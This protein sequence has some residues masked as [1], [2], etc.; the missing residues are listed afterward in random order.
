M[1]GRLFDLPVTMVSE[2]IFNS[3][4][5]TADDALVVVD[6]GLPSVASQMLEALSRSEGAGPADISTVVCTHGHS[7]HVGGVSTLLSGCDAAV[8]LPAR[9]ESYLAGELPRA[10]PVIESSVRFMPVY[11]EQPFSLR[12]LREFL[13]Q[14]RSIGWGAGNQMT[15]DFD[16]AGFLS[17]GDPVPSAPN[18]TTVAAPGHTDDSTCLHH[19]ESSTLISGDAVVTQD[20]TAWFNPEYV[21]Y[22]DALE[23]AARLKELD[24]RHLLP[25]HGMPIHGADIWDQAKHPGDRP[26]GKGLLARCSR[27]FGHWHH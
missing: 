19:R 15:V 13:G 21:D 1:T 10:F 5:I 9:C 17:D 25:G 12:G 2:W 26:G 11:R 22:A 24:V 8:H 18:W 20:G 7:D 16:P 23:T 4:A 27:R 6:P 3:Y 14:A